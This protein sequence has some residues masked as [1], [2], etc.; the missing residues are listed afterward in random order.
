MAPPLIRVTVIGIDSSGSC[1]PRLVSA[2][3]SVFIE[4]ILPSKLVIVGQPVTEPREGG[5]GA[6]HGQAQVTAPVEET[7]DRIGQVDADTA[8]HVLGLVA[9][10]MGR[11]G[12]QKACG[13]RF[14]ITRQAGIQ[15]VAQLVQRGAR[16]EEHKSELQ[17]REN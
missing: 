1:S 16:S 3:V 11:F 12:P 10:E 7:V 14:G 9:D 5:S 15:A 17:S 2:K 8:M 4:V 13:Q 6:A